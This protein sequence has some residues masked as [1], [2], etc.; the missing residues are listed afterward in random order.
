ML[1][2]MHSSYIHYQAC[3]VE[4]RFADAVTTQLAQH[5]RSH[6]TYYMQVGFWKRFGCDTSAKHFAILRTFEKMLDGHGAA[7]RTAPTLVRLHKNFPKQ[8]TVIRVR[9][10]ALGFCFT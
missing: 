3:I 10:F 9:D 2:R 8:K 4:R 5:N 6:S 1:A 7:N